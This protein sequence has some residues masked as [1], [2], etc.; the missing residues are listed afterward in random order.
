M[1]AGYRW[2][3]SD[4]AVVASNSASLGGDTAVTYPIKRSLWHL[5]EYA[6]L[7]CTQPVVGYNHHV[8]RYRSIW[9]LVYLLF[10]LGGFAPDEWDRVVT[11]SV[12]SASQVVLE[13]DPDDV[14]PTVQPQDPAPGS[15]PIVRAAVPTAVAS[16][17]LYP[18]GLLPRFHLAQ[19]PALVLPLY[20]SEV[21]SPIRWDEFTRDH[22]RG[23]PLCTRSV[24][25]E[26]PRPPPL[27]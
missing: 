7:D 5:G 11:P 6:R 2:C 14:L 9:A 23:P 19:P 25:V 8:K 10:L 15:G 22:S 21:V 4:R 24:P 13:A 16:D 12:S 26:A 18:S 3:S 27:V 20:S 17:L 1:S